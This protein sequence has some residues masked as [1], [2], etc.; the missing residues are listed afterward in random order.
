MNWSFLV[1]ATLFGMLFF[2]YNVASGIV[3]LGDMPDA[4]GWLKLVASGVVAF[5]IGTFTF[6]RDPE[7][8]WNEGPAIKKILLVVL[9]FG[10]LSA[11]SDSPGIV[12]PLPKVPAPAATPQ[13]ITCRIGG[14]AEPCLIVLERDW[15]ALEREIRGI[16][17]D[18]GHPKERCR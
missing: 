7:R 4:F 17:A 13:K 11:C 2:L 10:V 1:R 12:A 9:S 5:V 14:Q 15:Q 18:L 16:C 6:V 8:A 3:V